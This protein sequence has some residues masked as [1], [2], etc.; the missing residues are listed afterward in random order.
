[1]AQLHKLELQTQIR[2]SPFKIF[3][4]YKNKT[5]L[6]P[7]ISPDKLKTVEILE[8]DGKSVG[9]VRLWTYVMGIPVI[10]KDKIVAVDEEKKSITFEL[11]GGE[12]TKYFKNFKATF[13]AIA[14]TDK[15]MVKWTLEYEKASEDV[16]NLHSH[17]EFLVNMAME[18]DAYLVV[19]GDLME[20]YK[21]FKLTIHV[22]PVGRQI[23]DWT[24][25]YENE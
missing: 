7:K 8:G 13:E 6:M 24:L 14:Q 10:A 16:P 17:L 22:T 12:V 18:I 23:F 21:T 5:Y 1:M 11:I 9:S 19:E 20:L 15:N 3:D 4:V 25:D 2:S